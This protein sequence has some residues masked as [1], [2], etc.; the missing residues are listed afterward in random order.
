VT[1]TSR[2]CCSKNTYCGHDTNPQQCT[3]SYCSIRLCQNTT[4]L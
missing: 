3:E 4:S 1:H 2:I